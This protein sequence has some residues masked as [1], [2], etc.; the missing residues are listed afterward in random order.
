MLSEVL[1]MR[2][3]PAKT[4]LCSVQMEHSRAS[5][6]TDIYG[7]LFEKASKAEERRRRLSKTFA[8]AFAVERL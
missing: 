7:H 8:A 3:R 4:C 5:T 2:S 1:K 6:T